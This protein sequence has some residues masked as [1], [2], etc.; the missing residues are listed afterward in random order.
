MKY[1]EI[2]SDRYIAAWSAAAPHAEIKLI[3]WT[4]NMK[5]GG[6]NTCDWCLPPTLFMCGKCLP[7]SNIYKYKELT[8]VLQ[9]SSLLS[10]SCSAM[11]FV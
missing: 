3:V 7:N 5:V 8:S 11:S 9:S 2:P 4:A 6:K 10:A 1:P